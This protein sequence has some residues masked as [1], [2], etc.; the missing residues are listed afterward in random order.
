MLL[1]S[2][3]LNRQDVVDEYHAG[4]RAAATAFDPRKAESFSERVLQPRLKRTHGS[5]SLLG[6]QATSSGMTICVGAEHRMETENSWDESSTIDDD[7]AKHVYRVQAK[8]GQPIRLIKTITYHTSRGVPARELADRC[9][10]T[11]DRARYETLDEIFGKQRVWMDDFWARSDVEIDGQP[12]VQQAVR[13]N[14]YQ[15]AQATGK[16]IVDRLFGSE[17]ASRQIA[18]QASAILASR[19][20][21]A[22]RLVPFADPSRS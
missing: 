17:D 16:Q 12:D 21:A 11:L 5:R 15:L 19:S 10:R 22:G 8:A 2:Q 1:S 14:L 4:M 18:A 6:Y 13:W 9:D 20:G 7:L 3:I